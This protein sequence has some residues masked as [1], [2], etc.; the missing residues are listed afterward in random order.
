PGQVTVAVNASGHRP[1]ALPVEI[2]GTGV[3]R[4]E[5]ALQSG[6]QVQGVVRAAGGP[7]RDAR[8]TLVDAA[9]NVVGTTTTG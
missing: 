1:A 3:T 2:A 5:V 4:I 6:A 8:V 9:G 7:L